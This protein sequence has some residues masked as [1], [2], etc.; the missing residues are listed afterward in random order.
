MTKAVKEAKLHSSWINPNEAVRDRR[1]AIRR[2][3]CCQG[4]RPRSSSRRFSP[5]SSVSRVS[6]SSTRSLRSCSRSRLPA[7]PISIRGPSCGISHLV[8]PDNRRPVDFDRRRQALADV[9]A[10]MALPCHQRTAAIADLLSR[11]P[12]G[13]IK[14]L[15]TACGLGLRRARRR[16][17]HPGRVR[18]TGRRRHRPCRHRRLRAR[19]R[20]A[21]VDCD[22][23]APGVASDGRRPSAAGWRTLEDLARALTRRSGWTHLPERLHR[24]NRASGERYERIVDFRRAGAA[25]DAGGGAGDA[26]RFERARVR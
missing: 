3:A 19:A 25:D 11:W 21:R 16:P 13:T 1:H 5:S 2:G 7:F 8:D 15:V 23:P 10:I 4:R 20:R 9:H 22:R 17:V 26:S 18:P 14:M 12:D 24:R 6:A